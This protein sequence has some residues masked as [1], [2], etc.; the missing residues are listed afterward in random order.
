MRLKKTVLTICS[1]IFVT[2]CAMGAAS[3]TNAPMQAFTA[4]AAETTTN[5]K[6]ENV[7]LLRGE[8]T[9]TNNKQ[10]NG[11]Y[12]KAD[13]NSAPYSGD[14]TAR[15]GSDTA[16][17]INGEAKNATLIHYGD[18][19]Y[20]I[21]GIGVQDGDVLEIEGTFTGNQGAAV[22]S[23]VTFDYV[24]YTYKK[25]YWFGN[26]NDVVVTPTLLTKSADR[27]L[28]FAISPNEF[29]SDSLNWSERLYQDREGDNKETA[30][31]YQGSFEG[32]LLNMPLIKL[33]DTEY[34]LAIS[35]VATDPSS[36]S[37]QA[38]DILS[39][40]GYFFYGDKAMYIT[41]VSYTYD[42]VAWSQI[43]AP[44]LTVTNRETV[45][46]SNVIDVYPG[47][48]V[49]ELRFTAE[50]GTVTVTYPDD[51]TEN[52]AF[53]CK[54]GVAH[55]EYVVKIE[56]ALNGIRYEEYRTLRVG[57][58]SFEMENGAAVRLREGSNGLRFIAEM[59]ATDR[60]ALD[61]ANA[62]Y[63]FIIVPKDYVTTGYELTA[64][65]VFGANAVYSE[66]KVNGK[67][68]ML[69][70]TDLQPDD[71]DGDGKYELNASIVNILDANLTREFIGFAYAKVNG[72]YVFSSYFDGNAENNTRSMYYVAQKAIANRE[73][74]ETLQTL[75]IDRYADVL[76]EHSVTYTVN[77][78]VNHIRT[79]NGKTL[80]DTVYYQGELNASVNV[81][82]YSFDGYTCKTDSITVT[83]Y[84]NK[85]NVINLFYT[86]DVEA[87]ES[88][89]ITAWHAP[90]L[91][92]S[93]NYDN[94]NNHAIAEN[95]HAAGITS[96]ILGGPN[97]SIPTT[98]VE[99]AAFKNIIAVFY[100]HDV[101]SIVALNG[102]WFDFGTNDLP[103]FTGT[104]GFLGCLAW[105]EPTSADIDGE[106]LKAMAEAFD[107]KYGD[108]A[109]FM[110]NLFPSYAKED[111]LG[112]GYEQYVNAYCT[113]VLSKIQNG[114]KFISVDSYPIRE[115][116]D[117]S[118]TFLYD[119]AVLKYYAAA[120]G[121][122]A[123]ICLQSSGW[124]EGDNSN[125]RAPTAAEMR[126]QAYMAL[127]F[128]M[129]SYSWFTYAQYEGL[130]N[131]T[132]APVS[133]GGSMT[134]TYEAL[135]TV[136]SEISAFK[137]L[138]ASYTWN[139]IILGRKKLT[140]YTAFSKVTN[141]SAFKK[142]IKSASDTDFSS[143]SADQDYL[144]GIL[145]KDG[146]KAYSVVNYRAP[147]KN[148]TATIT[149]KCS[150]SKQFTVYRNGKT[151]I[152]TV[153][154]SGYK[155]VL[156]AGEGAFITSEVPET[157]TF[158]VMFKNW[159]GEILQNENVALNEVPSYKGATPT[160]PQVG[161]VVYKFVGWDK[162]VVAATA[163]VVYTAQYLVGE[164]HV[165]KAATLL[166]AIPD[167][168]GVKS[169]TAYRALTTY[170]AYVRKYKSEL[171]EYS[172]PLKVTRW[173]NLYAAHFVYTFTSGNDVTVDK[174][175]S[176][177]IE[178]KADDWYK[179]DHG[180]AYGGL[181]N[182]T[183]DQ[184]DGTYEIELPKLCYNSY[185]EVSFSVF[186][187][188]ANIAYKVGASE[189]LT[190]ESDKFYT[191][192]IKDGTLTIHFINNYTPEGVVATIPLSENVLSGEESLKIIVTESGWNC[193]WVSHIIGIFNKTELATD[194][195]ETMANNLTAKEDITEENKA[196]VYAALAEYLT[197]VETKFTAEEKANY[198][199]PQKVTD[200]KTYFAT[201]FVHTYT[202]GNDVTV[203][204]NAVVSVVEKTDYW[205][206][207]DHEN[208]YGGFLQVTFD[209]GDGTY[210]IELPK[211]CYNIYSEVS[212]GFYGSVGDN[213][214]ITYKVGDSAEITP[215]GS[216][217]FYTWVIK[218]G[219]LTIHLMNNGTPEGVIATIRLSDAVLSGEESLK[220]TATESGW[221]CLQFSHI[222]GIF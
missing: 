116:G 30:V 42:G 145:E 67:K 91:D 221:S 73:Q 27:G 33:S 178:T 65:N 170:L 37:A 44:E 59:S 184:G 46:S 212:F 105:D 115:N 18:S 24:T 50:Q 10:A 16:L 206:Q 55:S 68:L 187:S 172:E 89:E 39:I 148:T 161:D 101:Q 191:W 69:H 12:L 157:A 214:S 102:S 108:T 14:W 40:D 133:N 140:Q 137:D 136:N 36:F 200:L 154:G 66:T 144:M 114:K 106:T 125:S 185:D 5:V 15:Y 160:R 90:K 189:E 152:V 56:I 34:Y 181:L 48:S 188:S 194:V 129:D 70:F 53:V 138:Y 93:R 83:L 41:P 135:K 17:K 87:E 216:G 92:S 95:M 149:L 51:A 72:K 182:I 7:S 25:G 21:E 156:A 11:I 98:D 173:K 131:E 26:E 218:D 47:T 177:S 211:L 175:T 208:D 159:N 192:V 139:G 31:H 155:L 205:Y 153:N 6:V 146:Q 130:Q 54:N 107:R 32:T 166:D 213:S 35:D 120:N 124:N 204:K 163:D 195:A 162:E 81:T 100:A 13:K 123:H 220:I 193:I 118:T 49:D 104:D 75:Y 202:S 199:Q 82:P 128:G 151:E 207:D 111:Y 165:K 23:S 198:T 158:N 84:A 167:Y 222:I 171:G 28:Y 57:Y 209:Q 1:A 219:T 119:L 97:M 8:G 186:T 126:M 217:T 132:Q 86:S 141:F 197:Y 112:G 176:L 134:E 52:G 168:D 117:L 210:E 203:D 122:E 4:T 76:S 88:F 63:G 85:E 109:T 71:I 164:D 142:Y 196:T 94:D 103:D 174:T 43:F 113:E 179:D 20:F 169:D 74:A 190:G 22:G 143:V 60:N 29:P 183:F 78:T 38:G 121:A 127:A 9:G 61:T 19:S 110:V 80:T 150:G 79:G 77:Y 201:A 45:V 3:L 64:E 215:A 2:A 96:V 147:D 62:T 58:P 180:N 99:V